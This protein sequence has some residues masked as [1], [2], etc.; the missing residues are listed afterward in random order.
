[1]KINILLVPCLVSL[2]LVS[3]SQDEI[4]ATNYVRDE[5]TLEALISKKQKYY[6][7]NN[8]ELKKKF[9]G[10]ESLFL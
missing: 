7:A 9:S 8:A 10:G 3:C 2:F 6:R 4:E 5:A 1:M